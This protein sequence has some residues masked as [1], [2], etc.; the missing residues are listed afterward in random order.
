MIQG[1]NEAMTNYATAMKHAG[2]ENFITRQI[3]GAGPFNDLDAAR[4]NNSLLNVFTLFGPEEHAAARGNSEGLFGAFGIIHLPEVQMFRHGPKLLANAGCYLSAELNHRQWKADLGKVEF[5]FIPSPQSHNFRA[6]NDQIILKS[7]TVFTERTTGETMTVPART[8]IARNLSW[9]RQNTSGQYAPGFSIR[10]GKGGELEERN[11]VRML[12][13]HL[14]GVKGFKRFGSQADEFRTLGRYIDDDFTAEDHLVAC[15]Q[16]FKDLNGIDVMPAFNDYVAR[17][18]TA[19]EARPDLLKAMAQV[20][21]Y[22]RQVSE[23]IQPLGYTPKI[24]DEIDYGNSTAK[25]LAVAIAHTMSIPEQMEACTEMLGLSLP[26]TQLDANA[27]MQHGPALDYIMEDAAHAEARIYSKIFAKFTRPK[28]FEQAWL[29][30]DAVKAPLNAQQWASITQTKGTEKF[31]TILGEKQLQIMNGQCEEFCNSL[32]GYFSRCVGRLRKHP[33]HDQASLR[34][35]R[36][37]QL[38][39]QEV[40]RQVFQPEAQKAD[41]HAAL[42]TLEQAHAWAMARHEKQSPRSRLRKYEV[43]WPTKCRPALENLIHF[44]RET[45]AD[46]ARIRACYSAV[47]LTEKLPSTH[48]EAALACRSV[49]AGRSSL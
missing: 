27:A 42:E 33:D 31:A 20:C 25:Q 21:D 2:V 36:Q 41:L 44:L 43:E 3:V 7:D 9:A 18:S 37:A 11:A 10:D 39:C 1:F 24:A 14:S 35:A 19:L 5:D 4:A 30:P 8:V 12:W 17:A 40:Y 29:Q 15:L 32:A 23:R 6:I 28:A 22:S 38:A 48:A 34:I 26:T 46:P 49:E 16:S 47:T 13:G 45:D